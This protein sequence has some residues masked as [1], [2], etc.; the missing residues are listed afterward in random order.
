MVVVRVRGLGRIREHLFSCSGLGRNI[1]I[2]SFS[3]R[4][5]DLLV[6]LGMMGELFGWAKK[7]MIGNTYSS[8][9]QIM[10]Y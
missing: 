2:N 3:L 5:M 1:V 9:D 7:K 4:L 8:S 10:L 6:Y